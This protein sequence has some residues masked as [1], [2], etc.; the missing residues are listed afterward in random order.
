[1]DTQREWETIQ[2][3]DVD[4]VIP[5]RSVIYTLQRR[6]PFIWFHLIQQMLGGLEVRIQLAAALL[7]TLGSDFEQDP[8]HAEHVAM[9]SSLW[10]RF[11]VA[12]F[13]ILHYITWKVKILQ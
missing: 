8:V 3:L 13:S 7:G 1:M 11:F 5:T 10:F 2:T 4:H 9:T 12:S 6:P